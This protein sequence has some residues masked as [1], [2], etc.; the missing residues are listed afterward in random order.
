[1][2]A[3]TW[4]WLWLV[5]LLA[6]PAWAGAGAA[7]GTPAAELVGSPNWNDYFPFRLGDSWTY[8]W[9][10][11]GPMGVG[12]AAVRT[13]SFDGTSFL[14]QSVGYKLLSDD[15]TYH[16]YTFEDGV[17]A[18]HSSLESGRYF[19]YDPALV[20]AAPDM[21]VGEP[22]V[23]EQ[24]NGGRSWKT[25]LLGLESI[26]VPLGSFERALAIRVDM[27]GADFSATAVHYFAPRVGLVA[28]KYSLRDVARNTEL[29]TV[30]ARLRLARL[31]GVNVSRA[32]D[33]ANVPL[34]A[35]VAG[36]NRDLREQLR[37]AMDRRY[38]WSADFTG[39]RGR[40]DFIETG[41][42]PIHASFTV[43][44][45]L[46][47]K[48]DAPDDA[49]RALLRN[50]LSSFVTHR[51]PTDFDVTYAETTFVQKG[52]TPDGAVVL[53][54][55]GDPLMTTYTIKDGHI[56]EMGRSMGRVSYMA[57]DRSKLKTEDGRLITV[58]YDVIYSSNE[59]LATISVERTRD[60]YA[61]VGRFWVPQSRRVEREEGGKTVTRELTLS[62]L[63]TP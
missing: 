63:R 47:V 28:Y 35:S 2:T 58:E 25:T 23:N 54:A 43:N 26:E 18:I 53:V 50:E 33:L 48:V 39:F 16:L 52:K 9:R 5:W 7:R 62:E 56:V 32:A 30:D 29:L 51:K 4:H 46:S 49:S 61:R 3:S 44:P 36:E 1:M 17:L 57:R 24:A 10:T 13:R 42:A 12:G 15:G 11:A 34:R 22:R 60:G 8:D 55:A 21:R 59:T 41:K 14:N 20:L 45:D 38:T 6:T 31:S 19:D 37:A 27:Q 40:V